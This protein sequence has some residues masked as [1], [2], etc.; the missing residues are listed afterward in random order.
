MQPSWKND[1]QN[2]LNHLPTH[3]D[4]IRL[5]VVG[6]GNELNG[7]DMAGM[8]VVHA[9]HAQGFSRPNVLILA[10]ATAPENLT[11][12]IRRFAPQAVL[13]IDAAQMGEEV[14]AIRFLDASQALGV[15]ISTHTLG[16]E[17][18]AGYLKAEV[19]C[20]CWVLAIQAGETMVDTPMCA[21]VAAA[22]AEACAG[23]IDVI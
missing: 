15:G 4:P 7:D 18:M 10:G 2:A 20:D 9:M 16:L 11:G 12:A 14:G 6:V 19:G 17:M 1:L 21:A 13:F 23:I 8:S 3:P 5:V 22:V